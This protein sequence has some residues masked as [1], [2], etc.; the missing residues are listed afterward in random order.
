MALKHPT[1]VS[2]IDFSKVCE[3]FNHKMHS[4]HYIKEHADLPILRIVGEDS[5]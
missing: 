2:W 4:L 3:L 1:E 5:L